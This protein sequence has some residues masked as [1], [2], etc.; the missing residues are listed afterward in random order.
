V[1]NY[2]DVVN[3]NITIRTWK[4]TDV[5]GNCSSANQIISQ[6]SLFTVNLKSV[7]NSSV[8]TG[9]INTNLFLGYG[10]QAA[11]LQMTGLPSVGAPYTYVWDGYGKSQLSSTSIASPVFR[12]TVA[13]MQTFTVT[14]TN[15]YGCV[16]TATISIC[17]TDVRA[18]ANKI[19][20]CHAGA[21]G[22]PSQTLV[23][24]SADAAAHLLNHPGD[25][26]GS[27]NQ[28]PCNSNIIYAVAPPKGFVESQI[29]NITP[30]SSVVLEDLTVVVMPNPSSTYF[31]L[32]ISS[33][34]QAPVNMR[35]VDAAGKVIEAKQQLAPNSTLQIGHNYVSGVYIVEMIQGNT[36]K[37]VQL[38]KARG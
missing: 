6:G 29:K 21:D 31:T 25:R 20:I 26:L 14:V 36:R 8:F 9:G 17:V 7:P 15:K 16:S 28:T 10:A 35:V 34:N 11:T 27:F 22:S 18:A 33:K 37:A 30:E 24:S 23:V 12:P 38:I 2:T 3:G 13:G 1:I 4:A 19:T 32:K 5:A